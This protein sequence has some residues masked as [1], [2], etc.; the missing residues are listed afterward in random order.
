M[1]RYYWGD[2]E[3]KFWFGVQSSNDV[4]NLLNITSQP[5]SLIWHGCGC[6]VDFDQKND[7]F[8][9]AVF[10]DKKKT[11]ISVM[12]SSCVVRKPMNFKL[13]ACFFDKVC[14][15]FVMLSDLF[16]YKSMDSIMLSYFFDK[17][18][19]APSCHRIFFYKSRRIL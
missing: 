10:F 16:F 9:I 7:E 1:G 3:G 12:L 4:E 8:C 2:I 14:V 17:S 15:F 19:C 5:G 18:L 11:I 6:V 13:L